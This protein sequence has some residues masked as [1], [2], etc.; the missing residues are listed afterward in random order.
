MK[1][2][3]L[4]LVLLAI[5]ANASAHQGMT[6]DYAYDGIDVGER[7]RA[8]SGRTYLHPAVLGNPDVPRPVVVFLHGINKHQVHHPWMGGGESPDLR[9]VWDAYLREHRVSPAVLAAP[10]TTVACRLPQA[11]W[12]GF[13]LDR[14]LS[15]T[16]TATRDQ[17]RIDLTRVIL[18]AHS[19]AG[20]NHRGGAITAM[21]ASVHTR[22]GLI[23]DVCMEDLD[24][25]QLALAHPDTDVVI[26][27]QRGWRRDFDA[28][29]ESFTAASQR[30]GAR[31]LRLVEELPNEDRNPH[32]RIVLDSIAKWL[33]R[34]LPA[35]TP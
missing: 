24:A 32:A 33:P 30:N 4:A 16:I 8:W 3:L 28:F 27:Y 15:H 11:L 1:R 21:Q 34:W 12:D 13:D 20:C 23:I 14:F 35:S 18:V 7:D 22:A 10:S 31:A 2:A 5:P 17:V 29:R 19:G 25:P 6:I 9:A 26:T